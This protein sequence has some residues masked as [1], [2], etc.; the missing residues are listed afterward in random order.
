MPAERRDAGGQPLHLVDRHAA[1]EQHVDADA[2][3]AGRVQRLE[4]GVADIGRDHR[5]AAQPVR[6]AF[7]LSTMQRLSVP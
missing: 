5:D 1:A 4:F 7:R 2:A 3:H 6:M